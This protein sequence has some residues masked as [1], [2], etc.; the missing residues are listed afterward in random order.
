MLARVTIPESLG[1]QDCSHTTWLSRVCG[2]NTSLPGCGSDTRS[3]AESCFGPE[4]YLPEY[5][6]GHLPNLG[7]DLAET[8]S[9]RCGSCNTNQ[10]WIDPR[11]AL[12]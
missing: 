4:G 3:N 6:T 8:R 5:V 7:S 12:S 1:T 10:G 9:R 2:G 11:T